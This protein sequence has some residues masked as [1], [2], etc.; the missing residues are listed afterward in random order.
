MVIASLHIWC[1]CVLSAKTSCIRGF[2]ALN[3]RSRAPEVKLTCFIIQLLSTR[4]VSHNPNIGRDLDFFRPSITCK[5]G[6]WCE[7]LLPRHRCC[8]SAHCSIPNK[9]KE[10]S[11]LPLQSFCLWTKPPTRLAMQSMV[12]VLS[13]HQ[14][15]VESRSFSSTR[16]TG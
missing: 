6:P 7:G 9:R 15:P 3:L 12:S 13:G 10:N 11:L 2:T 16:S 1:S 5:R 8:R 14:H 4:T